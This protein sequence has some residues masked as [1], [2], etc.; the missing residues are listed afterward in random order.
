MQSVAVGDDRYG[1]YFYLLC[2]KE[3]CTLYQKNG[4]ENRAV[5][6]IFLMGR[7]KLCCY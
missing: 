6:V 1:V 7:V 3:N 2:E 4:S 5:F